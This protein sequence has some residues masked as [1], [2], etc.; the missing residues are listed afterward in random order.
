MT[1]LVSALGVTV[2]HDLD[3]LQAAA[4]SVLRC[5]EDRVSPARN[6][7]SCCPGQVTSVVK[8]DA[9]LQ[10]AKGYL[11]QAATAKEKIMFEAGS[12]GGGKAQKVRS[13]SST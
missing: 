7:T 10:I 12:G 4:A 6:A 13:R 5:R 9:A 8:M 11:E 3:G 1:M 2:T